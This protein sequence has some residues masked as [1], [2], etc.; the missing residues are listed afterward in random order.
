MFPSLS[1][2]LFDNSSFV[3]SGIYFE[4][5]NSFSLVSL[6][7][8]FKYSSSYVSNSTCPSAT[9]ILFLKKFLS[10]T[11]CFIPIFWNFKSINSFVFKKSSSICLTLKFIFLEED[12]VSNFSTKL[13]IIVL[14]YICTS[15]LFFNCSKTYPHAVSSK[16]LFSSIFS[17][18]FISS[19]NK[20]EIIYIKLS[21]IYTEDNIFS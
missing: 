9:L 7:A 19:I 16:N 3:M 11:F 13:N 6:I 10:I 17:N 14:K 15:V 12:I 2:N 5:N 4:L 21:S 18:P 20:R 1:F 8:S